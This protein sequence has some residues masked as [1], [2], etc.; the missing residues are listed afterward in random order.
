MKPRELIIPPI[1]LT[2]P[3]AVEIVRAWVAHN[4]QHVSLRHDHWTDPF[5]WRRFLADL[6]GHL[7]NAFEDS[8]RERSETIRLI[9]EGFNEELDRPTDIP[10]GGIM[11]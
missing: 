6:A 9:R 2:D 7:G 3:R 11:D 10:E 5:T 1:A 4:D 8:G